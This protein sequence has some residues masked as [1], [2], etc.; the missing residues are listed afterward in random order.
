MATTLKDIA[1]A[2][3][4]T[5]ATVSMVIN[6]KA[7]ISPA[8]REKVLNIAKELNYYPNII[9]RGLATRKSNAIGVIVPN[10]AS[11][12]TIRVLQGIKSTLRDVNYTLLL[13]DTIGGKETEAQLLMR[14]V[15]QGRVDGIIIISSSLNDE[16]LKALSEEK[17]PAVLIARKSEVI[18]SLSADDESAS[19]EAVKYLVDKGH[20]SIAVVTIKKSNLDVADRIRG[21]KRALIQSNRPFTEELIFEITDDN[22]M[23]GIY[24]APKILRHNLKPTAIF[25]PAGDMV[26]IGIIKEY[27]KRGIKIPDQMAVVGYDDIPA[28]E[29]VEPTLT[30]VRQPKLEMGDHAINFIIDRITGK[31]QE[32]NSKVLQAKFIIR[33]SA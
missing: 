7:K 19:Y 30:T 6:K 27:V 13:F 21:Y 2:S 5:A 1:K 23:D 28:A 18:C 25:C 24:I 16:D 32:W 17:L 31:T 9:A 4:V 8:T 15:R 10:L 14:V 22:M 29:V 3:G 26:A 20:E 33:E 12:F 11:S